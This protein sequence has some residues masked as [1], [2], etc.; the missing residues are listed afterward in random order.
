MNDFPRIGPAE[1]V[2]VTGI[3]LSFVVLSLAYQVFGWVAVSVAA[4]TCVVL[5]AGAILAEARREKAYGRGQ[6]HTGDTFVVAVMALVFA[7]S[8]FAMQVA[9]EL[10]L[11]AGP[12]QLLAAAVMLGSVAVVVL[13]WVVVRCSD[14]RHTTGGA[15]DAP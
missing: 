9:T 15:D 11:R 3:L 13:L 2:A 5:A 14:A 4:V 6:L 8:V 12:N 10:L 7:G 1:A